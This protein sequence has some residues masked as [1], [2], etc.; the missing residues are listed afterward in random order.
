MHVVV[1]SYFFVT[2]VSIFLPFMIV[3]VILIEWR[4]NSNW[5]KNKHKP[6]HTRPLAIFK[7]PI[8]HC[9]SFSELA[10]LLQRIWK[11]RIVVIYWKKVAQTEDDFYLQW[12]CTKNA[13]TVTKQ[14]KQLSFS[15]S[16]SVV[17]YMKQMP[18]KTVQQKV[19]NV[20]NW[21]NKK[22]KVFTPSLSPMIKKTVWYFTPP[23]VKNT[24]KPVET[25]KH[26]L[27]HSKSCKDFFSM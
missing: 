13:L 15:C 26:Y 19:W 27:S 20:K 2:P 8:I 12:N 14:W 24:R 17:S 5:S 11:K 23:H 22:K 25:C 6:Q 7:S 10:S 3:T 4:K 9:I 18:Y 16:E 1:H 21:L